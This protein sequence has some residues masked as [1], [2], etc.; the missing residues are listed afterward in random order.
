MGGGVGFDAAQ[1]FMFSNDISDLVQPMKITYG[2]V[3][4][5]RYFD[6]VVLK[7]NP[8]DNHHIGVPKKQHPYN[9]A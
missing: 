3:C 5:P 8:E 4:F 2:C 7:R 9:K 1:V 6:V